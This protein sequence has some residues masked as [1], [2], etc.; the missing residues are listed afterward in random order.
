MSEFNGG[1]GGNRSVLYARFDLFVQVVV[2]QLISGVRGQ[3]GVA[4]SVAFH[5]VTARMA[6]LAVQFLVMLRAIQR[7]QGLATVLWN[8]REE[9]SR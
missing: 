2:V 6:D 7:V 9:D 3:A 4:Q 8:G 1:Q 5:S